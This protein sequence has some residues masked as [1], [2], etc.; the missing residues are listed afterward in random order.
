MKRIRHFLSGPLTALSLLICAASVMFWIRSYYVAETFLRQD[1]NETWFVWIESSRGVLSVA[2]TRLEEMPWRYY[3]A[4]GYGRGLP[5][6]VD[7]IAEPVSAK[8]E[9]VK[10]DFRLYVFRYTYLEG[11][12]FRLQANART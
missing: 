9:E 2:A 3:V 1:D 6:L 7:P 10:H 5:A 12:L 4:T 11:D 8:P